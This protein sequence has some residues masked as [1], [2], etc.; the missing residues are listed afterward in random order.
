M[1]D[2]QG[3]VLI[4]GAN[5]GLGTAFV[6]KFLQSSSPYLGLFTVRSRSSESSS[7][8]EKLVASSKHPHTI[9]AVDLSSLTAVRAFARNI[10]EQVS[11]GQILPIRALVLNAAI[12]ETKGQSYTTDGLE[13]TFAVNYLG[14][15]LL[16]LLLL[17]SMDQDNGRIVIVSSFTHDP[18]RSY[19]RSFVT[20]KLVFRKPQL[21]AR[22]ETEDKPGDQF[23][24]GMRRYALSKT[25]MLMF[26]Y[27]RILLSDGRYELQRRLDSDS[28]L[29]NVAIM[30]LDPGGMPGTGITRTAPLLVRMIIEYIMPLFLGIINFLA[31]SLPFRTTKRSGGDLV[32]AALDEKELGKHPKT[33]NLNGRV[34]EI[35]SAE[36]RDESKQKELWE[37]SLSLAGIK[38]EE[39][40]LEHWK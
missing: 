34:K 2:L 11:S 16:V 3:T 4:T 36:T 38:E 39:T 37:G 35:T 6:S 23:M 15:F 5:G 32:Y 28:K 30:A 31:P 27:S 26:M 13:T 17:K 12:Q 1:P 21:M 24:A 10:N 19:N 9:A 40:V 25:L 29:H 22:P 20:D 8:L 33:I 14:N 18:E 7:V